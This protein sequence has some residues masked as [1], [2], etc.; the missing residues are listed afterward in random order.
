MI[1]IALDDMQLGGLH[2]SPNIIPSIRIL[3]KTRPV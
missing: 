3:L 2:P 1:S